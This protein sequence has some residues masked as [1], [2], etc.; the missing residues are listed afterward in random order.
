MAQ[1]TPPS[2]SRPRPLS[3]PS[4]MSEP[5]QISVNRE[6]NRESRRFS[7]AAAVRS[8]KQEV[9]QWLAGKFPSRHKPEFFDPE[10]GNK[11][12]EP[13]IRARPLKSVIGIALPLQAVQ[14]NRGDRL[15]VPCELGNFRRPNAAPPQS[16]ERR[17]RPTRITAGRSKGGGISSFMGTWQPSVLFA[18]S[19]APR[20]NQRTRCSGSLRAAVP[21]G[22]DQLCVYN[23]H[24]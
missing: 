12:A 10:P 24:T 23:T 16:A 8:R 20:G 2:R 22:A 15:R 11:S 18:L 9:C 7:V 21:D 6:S 3:A 13:G 4:G 1:R 5:A 14:S 17:A 19:R